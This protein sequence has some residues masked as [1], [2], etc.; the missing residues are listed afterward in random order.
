MERAFTHVLYESGCRISEIL[1][2]DIKDIQHD[3]KGTYFYVTGKTGVRKIPLFDSVNDLNNWLE[4]HPLK[5]PNSPLWVGG[6]TRNFNKRLQY[7]PARSLF[8]RV[9]N[10]SAITKHLTPHCF[11]HSR[12]Y[13]LKNKNF[14]EFEMCD[15]FGWKYGS[16]MP[17]IY[18]KPNLDSLTEKLSQL[19]Q[20][21]QLPNDMELAVNM[22]DPKKIKEFFLTEF[23]ELEKKG[24][25]K[26]IVS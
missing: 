1:R 20:Q 4:H 10:R 9:I 22:I 17:R 7:L 18:I 15:M 8:L 24:K 6:G 14:T 25:L 5:Q 13:E 16:K 2:L 21:K 12:A 3:I 19:Y 26:V 23:K 11:R